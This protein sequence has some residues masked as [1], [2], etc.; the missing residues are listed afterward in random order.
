MSSVVK[1][2][3]QGPLKKA[4]GKAVAAAATTATSL[5]WK[6]LSWQGRAVLMG[7]S[8]A[9]GAARRLNNIR[10]RLSGGGGGKGS[11]KLHTAAAAAAPAPLPAMHVP[12]GLPPAA[13]ALAR[14]AGGVQ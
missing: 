2:L 8:F 11:K 14:H 5:A 1:G 10:H 12:P 9:L 4:A 13:A 3:A 7:G 6:R